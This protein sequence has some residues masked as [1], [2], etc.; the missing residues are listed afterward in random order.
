[1]MKIEKM[2]NENETNKLNLNHI[3]FN[4]MDGWMNG[5]KDK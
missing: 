4:K 5:T 2:K 3:K 1:M